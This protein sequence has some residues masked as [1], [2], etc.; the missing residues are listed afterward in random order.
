M[1][2]LVSVVFPVGPGVSDAGLAL[3]DLFGQTYEKQEVGAVLNGC[4][5]SVR[6]DVLGRK[7]RRL[8]G[9]DLGNKPS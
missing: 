5:E 2:D 9:I 1:S 6:G 8:R 3:D 7:G 4:P